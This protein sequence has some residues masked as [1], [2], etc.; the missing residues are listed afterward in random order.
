MSKSHANTKARALALFE[1]YR[2][3]D[4]AR[5]SLLPVRWDLLSAAQVCRTDVWDG[6]AEFLSEEYLSEASRDQDGHLAIGTQL[7][8]LGA[9]LNQAAARFKAVG[10]ASVKLFFTCLDGKASTDEAD[11]LRKL[12]D[13]MVKRAFKRARDN[14]EEID[15]SCTPVYGEDVRK[16]CRAFAREGSAQARRPACPTPAHAAVLP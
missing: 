13:K 6:F 10:D 11:W 3:S 2:T 12:K 5:A 16:I 7:D 14:G 9:A 4:G 8:Y 1:A 15:H